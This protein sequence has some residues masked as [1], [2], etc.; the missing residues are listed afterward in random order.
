[1][2]SWDVPA[3]VS[4]LMMDFDG[5]I[6][7][8]EMADATAWRE[9]FA[10][11]GVPISL[12]EY[13][14]FWQTWGWL[15]LVPTPSRLLAAAPGTDLAAA[16][17]RRLARYL[18][19]TAGLPAVPG[20][21]AWMREAA[22]RGMRIAVV[23]NDAG[24]RVEGHLARLGLDQF[25]TTIVSSGEGIA[26]KPAPDLYVRALDRLGVGAHECVAA[27]DSP[28]GVAAALTAGIRVI[29][30]P[31]Q[32]TSLLDLDRASTIVKS[33]PSTPL[34]QALY[35]A[36]RGRPPS[37]A[38]EEQDHLDWVLELTAMESQEPWHW[39]T[40]RMLH[41]AVAVARAGRPADHA[42][43]VQVRRLVVLLGAL[44]WYH[45]GQVMHVSNLERI[46]VRLVLD[47]L[48]SD[49]GARIAART[50][51]VRSGWAQLPAETGRPALLPADRAALDQM[52]GDDALLGEIRR[53]TL[54]I[55]TAAARAQLGVRATGWGPLVTLAWLSRY[56][57][58]ISADFIDHPERP[59][60]V[61][62]A[63]FN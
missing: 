20:I 58:T 22:G 33:V 61:L 47:L 44:A 19:L 32:L 14:D 49:E 18:E 62:S 15:R 2:G 10:R 50:C 1:M 52:A 46:P 36:T 57:G 4:V 23:S 28:H 54:R 48:A 7:D 17:A 24:G 27:E 38:A 60:S 9:E 13:A 45:A 59:V 39:L 51:P 26:R 40:W 30:V 21:E 35:L 63:A 56:D 29:A 37:P 12:T 5:L 8:S 41:T 34:D 3:S 6:V 25:V 55:L 16:Q 43:A 42:D 31:N 11:A 53:E